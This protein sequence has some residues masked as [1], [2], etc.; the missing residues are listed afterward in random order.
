MANLPNKNFRL[1]PKESDFLDKKTG[2]A[3]EIL[4]DKD[5]NTLKLYDGTTTGGFPLVSSTNITDRF[6]AARKA[7]V[8]Y[9]VTIVSGENGNLYALNGETQPA[10]SFV[11]GYTYVFD[12]SDQTNVYWPNQEG[13]ANNQHPLNFSADNLNG[14]LAGG[15]V[16]TTNV[17]YK[18]DGKTVDKGTYWR[19]FENSTNRQVWINVT[20]DTPSTLYYWCQNH[21]NMGAEITVADPGTGAGGASID[22]AES[23][24][25]NPRAGALWF[26][27]NTGSLYVYV[28]DTS[29]DNFWIQPSVPVPDLSSYATKA[30]ADS[31]VQTALG[32]L[33]ITNESITTDDSSPV[34]FLSNV[35]FDASINAGEINATGL[36]TTFISFADDTIQ[37]TAASLGNIVFNDN[38]ITSTDSSDITFTPKVNFSSDIQIDNEL[39][40]T[41]GTRQDTAAFTGNVVFNENNVLT[42]DSSAINFTTLVNFDADLVTNSEFT[43]G[44]GTGYPT[45]LTTSDVDPDR[46]TFYGTALDPGNIFHNRRTYTRWKSTSQL[47]GNFTN[48][49]GTIDLDFLSSDTWYLF[50]PAGA[51]TLN[52]TEIPT[53]ISRVIT[54]T[55]FIAQ[56]ATPYIP[57]AV[58]VNSNSTAINWQF[59][60]VPTGSANDIDMFQFSI[61]VFDG[62]TFLV[63]GH[64]NVYT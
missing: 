32:T 60:V 29:G 54:F 57:T 50:E 43:F 8:Y 4:F 28:T 21:L 31:A 33:V 19:D 13:G 49:S 53:T 25:I 39:V 47:F 17:F 14:E 64:H 9:N 42:S 62:P 23:A 41:D 6:V 44:G 56:G 20:N 51:L 61:W 16:Y 10:L 11:V 58:E 45:T 24:P 40:F 36:D 63:L 30:Y 7:T 27:S 35:N 15:T 26:N 18:L 34:V 1:E 37:T 55:V 48:P 59:G 12:Q 38:S 5:N 22:I 46:W 2:S 52:F 3:G